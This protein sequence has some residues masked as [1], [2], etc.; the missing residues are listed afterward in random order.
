[1]KFVSCSFVGAV[2]YLSLFGTAHSEPALPL[3]GEQSIYV[4][5]KVCIYGSAGR[6]AAIR[7]LSDDECL[8]LFVNR[9]GK[10]GRVIIETEQILGDA[11]EG[12]SDLE[13]SD[14]LLK[15]GKSGSL[16]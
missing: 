16:H 14:G 10:S 4:D 5:E 11:A 9:P 15:T 12:N 2:L 8:S 3:V 1:M 7:M 13:N 6:V